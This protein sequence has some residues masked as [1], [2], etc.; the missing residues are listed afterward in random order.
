M[1]G[2]L[3][4]GGAGRIGF[5]LVEKLVE[6]NY[7]VTIL[8]L[9]S[10]DSLKRLEKYKKQ[11]KVVYGDVEDANLV[12]DLVKRNDIVIDYAG[13]MPPLANLN[14]SIANSTNYIGT[15]NIVDAI[16]E[17][18]PECVL[19]YMSFISI[20]GTTENA[21]RRLSIEA[22]STHPDDYYSVSLIRSEDYI[23]SNLKKYTILRMPIVLT[24]KNYY[25][26]HMA[27]GKKFDFITSSDLN[28]IVIGI[29]KSSK[30]HGKVYNISG[31]KAKSEEIID[32]LYKTTGELAIAGRNLY[33]G[34]YDDAKEIEKICKIDYTSIDE[35]FN[36]L[37]K[38]TPKIKKLVRKIV[39]YPKYVILQN[40]F[41]KISSK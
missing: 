14:E 20:Y 3:I 24:N 21:K 37:Q 22:E 23:K 40:K 11:I 27:L 39:N 30:I 7:N 18:N 34:E 15:K 25:I 5:N 16:N 9:E 13:I 41:K 4:T 33:Y 1:K 35:H 32:N 8:D 31:F 26:R 6:T 28:D 10:N 36:L 2:V 29:M 38:Q 19:I 17:L 12:R